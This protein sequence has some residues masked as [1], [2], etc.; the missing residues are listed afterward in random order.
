[1]KMHLPHSY[2]C[3]STITVLGLLAMLCFL[4]S[5]ASSGIQSE[6]GLIRD[7]LRWYRSSF[8]DII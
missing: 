4:T 3:G 5:A 8:V 1:M 6:K 7:D 2:V